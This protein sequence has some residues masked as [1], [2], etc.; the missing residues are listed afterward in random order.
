MMAGRAEC[1][2]TLSARLA[3]M[4]IDDNRTAY[5]PDTRD[6]N[7]EAT[8]SSEISARIARSYR[9]IN[10]W[11]GHHTEEDVVTNDLIRWRVLG[12]DVVRVTIHRGER[13]QFRFTSLHAL[14]VHGIHR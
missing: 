13:R 14:G 2:P 11:N 4:G 12:S 6:T 3:D 7:E 5:T 1:H 9:S 8:L 10:R